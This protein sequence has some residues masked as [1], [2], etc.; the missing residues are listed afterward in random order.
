MH[1]SHWRYHL[2]RVCEISRLRCSSIGMIFGRAAQLTNCC[3]ATAMRSKSI[4]REAAFSRCR[5]QNRS[6]AQNSSPDAPSSRCGALAMLRCCLLSAFQRICKTVGRQR[7][8][9]TESVVVDISTCQLARYTTVDIAAR[10]GGFGEEQKRRSTTSTTANAAYKSPLKPTNMNTRLA[11][12][13]MK[14]QGVEAI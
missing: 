10:F 3:T 6:W 1:Q 11:P 8:R 7:C 13:T 5:G 14:R 12:E 4:W 9:L 2:R